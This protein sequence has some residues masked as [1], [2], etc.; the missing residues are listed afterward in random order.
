M[1]HGYLHATIRFNVTYFTPSILDRRLSI[2]EHFGSEVYAF[3]LLYTDRGLNARG[4][5]LLE[6]RYRSGTGD[7]WLSYPSRAP[8][9]DAIAHLD[10]LLSRA[11]ATEVVAYRHLGRLTDEMRALRVA[12]LL[13]RQLEWQADQAADEEEAL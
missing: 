11:G 1:H 13:R 6:R 9:Y 10:R 7:W 3:D 2:P 8:L 4:T 12:G 5:A